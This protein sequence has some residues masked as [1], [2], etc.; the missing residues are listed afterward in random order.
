M[1]ILI[2]G[3]T[4]FIGQ[5]LWKYLSEFNDNELMG[6]DANDVRSFD[7][8]KDNLSDVIRNKHE[9]DLVIHL[10]GIGGVRESLENPKKYWDTNVEGTKKILSFFKNNYVLVASSSSQY[11]PHLNPYAASK[12]LIE[13]IPHKQVC[14]MRFHTVYGPNPRA[15]MFFD[16]LLNNELEYVTNHERDFI[17]ID[18]LCRA[19]D[20]IITNKVV[21]TIDIGTGNPVKIDKIRPDLPVKLSTV[22]ER[23][24]TCANTAKLNALGWKPNIDV[25]DFLKENG[26]E[27]N[28]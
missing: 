12:H 26:Y 3:H 25:R 21:G 16:K 6:L 7:I 15:K 20:T 13:Y 4:G 8:T 22:G 9:I 23:Q 27:Y 28:A 17:H 18:D 14:F 24:R 2:T 11:E 10:A 1:K 19:I 5:S